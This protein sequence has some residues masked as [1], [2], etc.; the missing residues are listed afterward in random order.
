MKR[1]KE[2]Y[3]KKEE[4][5]FHPQEDRNVRR[6]FIKSMNAAKYNGAQIT[7]PSGGQDRARSTN[8]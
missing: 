2:Q 1:V 7:G 3:Q 5:G 6:Y 8:P 4:T